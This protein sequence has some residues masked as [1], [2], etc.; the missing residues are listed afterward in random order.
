MAPSLITPPG[1]CPCWRA[2]RPSVSARACTSAPRTPA[3]SCTA[4]GKSSTTPSTRPSAGTAAHRDHPPRGLLGRGPRRRARH[5]RGHRAEDRADRRRGRLHQAACRRQVRRR[6]LRGLGR[7]ARRRRVGGQRAVRA[8]RRRGG[9]RRQDPPD[10]LP[11]GRAGPV[12]GP[13]IEPDAGRP[14]QAVRDGSELMSVGKA[15]A[16]SPERASATGRTGRSSA[17]R[18][19]SYEELARVPARPRSWCPG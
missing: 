1:T 6:L 13:G 8:P 11:P 4:S 19:F 18:Q 9:P 16:A 14:L 12:R 15:S 2:S 17:R 5:P 3:A 7:P 10:G